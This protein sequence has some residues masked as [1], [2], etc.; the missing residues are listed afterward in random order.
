[1]IEVLRV[2]TAWTTAASDLNQIVRR[3]QNAEQI[4]FLPNH[5][6][7]IP[8]Q[9]IVQ[10][11]PMRQTEIVL[12]IK[13]IIILIGIAPRITLRLTVPAGGHAGEEVFQRIKRQFPAV[14]QVEIL[15][16]RC[17]PEFITKLPVMI[18]A[19]VRKVIQILPIRIDASA[20]VS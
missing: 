9:P 20:R 13:R 4:I 17:A 16:R 19:I 6:V 11:K 3:I 8:P 12:Q 18:S 5:S 10:G 15:V 14:V 2:K 1:M 7:V